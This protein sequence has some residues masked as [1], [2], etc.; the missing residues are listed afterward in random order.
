MKELKII[1]ASA[2]DALKNA[3]ADI[4]YV[5]AERS[6]TQ[7]FNI[8]REGFNLLRSLF[9]SSLTLTGIKDGKKGS[10]EIN[11]FDDEKIAQAVA[12]CMAASDSSR[13]DPDWEIAP[14]LGEL[15]FS[16][17]CPEPDME[18][19]FFRSRELYE[20]IK[21][22]Y[23]LVVLESVVITHKGIT[24]VYANSN[25]SV[26]TDVSGKYHVNM[27]YSA[28][29][30][31]KSSSFFYSSFSTDKLD[32]AFISHDSV[33]RG[34]EDV[35]KQI[36]TKN[37]G[38][39][40]EGTV[41]FTPECAGEVLY[42][43]LSSFADAE[44]I[45]N[46]TSPWLDKLEKAVADEK[47]TVRL[48]PRGAD[49]VSGAY[50]TLDG[51]LTEDFN[52]IDK[53]VLKSF[54]MNKYFSNK[55]GFERSPNTCVSYMCV[56]PGHESSGSIISGIEKGLMVNRISGGTPGASGEFSMVAKNSFL[57]ENGKIGDA[58]SE[59]TI[60]GNLLDLLKNIRAISCD[61]EADGS[62]RMPWIAFDGVTI[63]G[64]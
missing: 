1:A 19:L 34:L 22:D 7:E 57:I 55:T 52:M 14:G 58:V 6:R 37:L 60:N 62:G 63:A 43:A 56:R 42:Y 53:G 9:D 13:S 49:A 61:T 11:S 40:F 32:E 5:T 38:G 51:Y 23:P 26:F 30:G 33:H 10:A 2:L 4:A 41:I 45:Q 15:E 35:Q 16:D 59:V 21:R 29:T 47:L 50:W 20:D 28:Q 25:G 24:E 64:K 8:D 3:G 12:D 39:K 44:A 54:F 31:E 36:Y 46:K 17:G 48:A 18:A 27:S